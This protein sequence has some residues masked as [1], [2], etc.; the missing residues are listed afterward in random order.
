MKYAAAV[1][2]RF[3]VNILYSSPSR[4]A[5][6]SARILAPQ[7]ELHID[8]RL[9]EINF[10]ALEGLT[11]EEAA[12]RYPEVYRTWMERPGYASFPQGESITTMRARVIAVIADL[13]R[14]HRSQSIAVVSHAGVNRIA[15]AHALDLARRSLFRLAQDYGAVNVIEYHHDAR[16]IVTLMNAALSPEASSF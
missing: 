13:L 15:L 16:A 1:L 4:R 8:D 11:Y 2:E 7:A 14:K 9:S 5:V 12:A 10:G 3:N 6:E